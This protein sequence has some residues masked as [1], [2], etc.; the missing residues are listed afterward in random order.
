M[1]NNELIIIIMVVQY[2][3]FGESAADC[4]AEGDWSKLKKTLADTGC[5]VKREFDTENERSAYLKGIE[6]L[7]GWLDSYPLDK[8]EVKKMLRHFKQSEINNLDL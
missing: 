8:D 4:A 7:N 2:V 6:D 1:N 3:I 5:V